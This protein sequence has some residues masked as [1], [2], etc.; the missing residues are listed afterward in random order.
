MTSSLRPGGVSILQNFHLD[1][2]RCLWVE[3][4]SGSVVDCRFDTRKISCKCKFHTFSL[5][6]NPSGK[7]EIFLF[8]YKHLQNYEHGGD[9]DG[10]YS[11]LTT[12][13]IGKL[14]SRWTNPSGIIKLPMLGGSNNANIWYVTCV[15]FR[16]FHWISKSFGLVLH[17]P[18]KSQIPSLPR[19]MTCLVPLTPRSCWSQGDWW[20]HWRLRMVQQ[21]T[22]A[23]FL[24]DTLDYSY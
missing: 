9:G 15:I 24:I 21:I 13:M 6:C 23:C 4:F 12:K 1:R 14:D 7:C 18:G 22:A 16:D 20:I 17:D 5:T 19:C 8:E 11:F 10:V 3:W 2:W